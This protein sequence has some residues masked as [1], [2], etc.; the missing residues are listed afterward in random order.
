MVCALLMVVGVSLGCG[1]GGDELEDTEFEESSA[2]S[3][4]SDEAFERM[5]AEEEAMLLEEER[6]EELLESDG[7]LSDAEKTT[8]LPYCSGLWG[9]YAVQEWLDY[10]G[11]SS[12]LKYEVGPN[13]YMWADEVDGAICGD[14]GDDDFLLSFYLGNHAES[15]DTLSDML[16]WYSTHWWLQA[17]FFMVDFNGRLYQQ[18]KEGGRDNYNYYMCADDYYFKYA[19]TF[20]IR[21]Y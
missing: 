11:T 16:Y 3:E 18:T 13:C 17:Y 7:E 19:S 15:A 10:K 8:G 9:Y 5:L 14:D 4:I 12:G 2:V 21:K 1:S 20:R 6:F